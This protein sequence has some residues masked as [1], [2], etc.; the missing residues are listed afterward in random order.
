MFIPVPVKK[1]EIESNEVVFRDSTINADEIVIIQ[2]SPLYRDTPLEKPCLLIQFK[3]K[4]EIACLGRMEDFVGSIKYEIRN[5]DGW[6][7]NYKMK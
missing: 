5:I 4:T 3:N 2:H 6:K 1:I 7:P